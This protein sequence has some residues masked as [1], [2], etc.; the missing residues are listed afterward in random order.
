MAE[1]VVRELNLES[2]VQQ[3]LKDIQGDINWVY[4]CGSMEDDRC[5]GA[6]LRIEGRINSLKTVLD[7]ISRETK[8]V[9]IKNQD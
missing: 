5:H 2:L 9:E 3:V 6:F 1:I 4:P 7:F 8:L